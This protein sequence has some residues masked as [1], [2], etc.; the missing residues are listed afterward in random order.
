MQMCS[1]KSFCIQSTQLF[2]LSINSLPKVI[3][4][5]AFLRQSLPQ[6]CIHNNFKLRAVLST[7]EVPPNAARRRSDPQWRGGFSLGIDLGLSRTGLAISKGFSFKPLTVLEL[8]GQK[9]ETRLLEIAEDEEADEFIIGLPK[10]WDGKE[11]SQ[12]NKVRS[13]AGRIAV[14]AAERGWRV[15]LQDEHGT[16]TDATYWMINVGLS[17]GARQKSIDAYAAVMVL[18][19]YYAASGE[20]TELVIPK[21]LDLQDKL[22][23]GPPKDIDFY[24]E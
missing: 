2:P 20:G 18:E 19:R 9:L 4:T 12:C 23:K 15:Y 7:E 13:V 16:S 24:P 1:L 22:R 17:K 14:R 11:T 10:S 6:I 8:R 5:S 21:R 3:N